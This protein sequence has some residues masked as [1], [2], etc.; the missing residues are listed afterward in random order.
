MNKFDVTKK[1]FRESSTRLQ[2]ERRTARLI[3]ARPAGAG[4]RARTA[5]TRLRPPMCRLALSQREEQS[6]PEEQQTARPPA[7]TAVATDRGGRIRIAHVPRSSL[8]AVTNGSVQEQQGERA[9]TPSPDRDILELHPMDMDAQA[10][11]AT[12]SQETEARP[13][14]Q[15]PRV[16]WF[17]NEMGWIVPRDATMS[18]RAVNEIKE[19]WNRRR[20]GKQQSILVKDDQKTW[21][22][23]FGRGSRITI[24]HFVPSQEGGSHTGEGREDIKRAP[25][26]HTDHSAA[27]GDRR[28]R[29]SAVCRTD[30]TW[31]SPGLRRSATRPD[32]HSVLRGAP[33]P[34]AEPIPPGSHPGCVG[35]QRALTTT[36]FSEAHRRP[37][38]PG[39]K[40]D[41]IGKADPSWSR[42]FSFP[43][44]P[45]PPPPPP[46]RRRP[47]T[48]PND[49]T[50]D[51]GN[52]RADEPLQHELYIY[53]VTNNS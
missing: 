41:Q 12:P 34:S 7:R 29:S 44:Y 9:R 45:P 30:P 42:H 11:E 6:R 40:T 17:T 28:R 19:R 25:V 18:A 4:I 53:Y 37:C 48:T 3:P 49:D 20:K 13:D 15:A 22:V 51:P 46:R 16:E 50:E 36:R 2:Q 32:H 27:D 39:T 43:G 23:I 26:A 35:P 31:F 21:K 47:T 52:L 14:A 33:R 24:R 8:E 1:K 38:A 5:P 10:E